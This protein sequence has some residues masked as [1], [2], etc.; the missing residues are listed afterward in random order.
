MEI[1][2][3][4]LLR[5]RI[6]EH[7]PVVCCGLGSE[8]IARWAAQAPKGLERAVLCGLAGGLTRQVDA[9]SAHLVTS[10]VEARTGRRWKP[11][12]WPRGS[13]PSTDPMVLT[14]AEEVVATEA[15][16]A[17]LAGLTGATLV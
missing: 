2:R 12:L 6:G 9:G 11:T 4:A 17:A 8:G 7:A 13:E 10:V 1:E 3:A 16:K 15:E 5:A 14:T